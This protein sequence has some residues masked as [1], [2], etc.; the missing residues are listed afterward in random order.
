MLTKTRPQDGAPPMGQ[1][2]K[3]KRDKLQRITSAA[4]ELFVSKGYDDTTTR[5][6]ALR[7][8]VGMGTVFTY[9]DNK[10]DL[11]FLIANEDLAK[12]TA[13]AA[14]HVSPAAPMLS[15]L[16]AIFRDHYEFFAEQPELSR[17]TLREMAFYDGGTQSNRFKATRELLIS[18]VHEAV[19]HGRE[20]GEFASA[21]DHR[22]IGWVIFCVYQSELR[23]WLSETKQDVACGMASL[24]R[25]IRV[26]IDGL[27]PIQVSK[28]GGRKRLPVKRSH[29]GVR[30]GPAS[31]SS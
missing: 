8:G 17:L 18:L 14:A 3:N 2:E 27:S 10:R 11:L 1:R 28:A 15:N 29:P 12:T 19:R 26:V 20:R 9:A 6:I 13:R 31:Q 4:R 5:E 22:L 25:A 23:R 24:D 30:S 7:A 21:E 16:M